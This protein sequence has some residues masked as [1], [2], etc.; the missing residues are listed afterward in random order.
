MPF[1]ITSLTQLSYSR[2]LPSFSFA[3]RTC[4]VSFPL[5]GQMNMLQVSS[6]TGQNSQTAKK[7]SKTD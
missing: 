3:E 1:Q 2:M 6:Y 7:E 5:D 4:V